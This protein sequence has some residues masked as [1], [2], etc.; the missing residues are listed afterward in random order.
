M[1]R[2]AFK[3]ALAAALSQH[4]LA[5][6]L[7]RTAAPSANG[8][9]RVV[10]VRPSSGENVAL[11]DEE[12]SEEETA[13]EEVGR[14]S[15]ATE[16]VA[17]MLRSI[18][19]SNARLP[20]STAGADLA[21]RR[22]AAEAQIRC[23][24]AAAGLRVEISPLEDDV[25][26]AV[27]AASAHI[28]ATQGW[29]PWPEHRPEAPS[30]RLMDVALHSAVGRGRARGA[31]GGADLPSAYAGRKRTEEVGAAAHAP[32]PGANKRPRGSH[33]SLLE[34]ALDEVRRDRQAG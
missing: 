8:Q 7:D 23:L 33:G 24:A 15:V 1:S 3:Q 21:A 12:D 2:S 25:A 32:V 13:A 10:L 5:V 20:A 34:H 29:L 31:A 30:A 22:A 11:E 19:K 16:F 17:R 28:V 26:A 14:P 6:A 4:D 18:A 27:D 9:G